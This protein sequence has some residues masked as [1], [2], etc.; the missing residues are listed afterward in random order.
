MLVAA[1]PTEQ[2]P[3]LKDDQVTAPER[4][5]AAER[6][7]QCLKD[8]GISVELTPDRGPGQFRFGGGTPTEQARANAIYQDCYERF[9]REIDMVYSVQQPPLSA[10]ESASAEQR[11]LTCL[12]EAG[13]DVS[14]SAPKDVWWDIR[15][16]SPTE[17]ARCGNA[18]IAEFGALP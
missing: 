15:L 10:S 4:Q 2:Q 6:T 12:Q 11:L 8:Q 18:V 3:Q 14:L 5:A 1:A 13:V 7:I 16:T 9:E 17:F